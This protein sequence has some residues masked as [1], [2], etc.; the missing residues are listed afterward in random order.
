MNKKKHSVALYKEEFCCAQAVFSTYAR[1]WGMDPEIFLKIGE[2]FGAGIGG[3]A[4]ICGAVTGAIMAIGLKYGRTRPEDEEKKQKTRTL[5]KEFVKQF[6]KRNDSIECKQ[7]LGVDISIPGG[8]ELAEEKGLI[9]TLCPKLVE[10]A[11]DILDGLLNE[12]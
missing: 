2:A 12:K 11:V 7:L 3:M 8:R 10:D 9:D 6:E 5:V 4:S 1:H